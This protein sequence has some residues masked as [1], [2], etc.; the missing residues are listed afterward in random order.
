MRKHIVFGFGIVF[1]LNTEYYNINIKIK[2][3]LFNF[4]W[5][6]TGKPCFKITL[7]CCLFEEIN[8]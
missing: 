5:A 2:A 8:K 3:S 1:A 6:R 7:Y 4:S